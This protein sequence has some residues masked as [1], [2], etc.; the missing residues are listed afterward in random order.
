MLSD[1]PATFMISMFDL[2]VCDNCRDMSKDGDHELMAKTEART[3]FLLKEH[4]FDEGE[5]GPALRYISRRNPHNPGGGQM[6]LYLR[7]Q[8]EER[9]MKVWGSEVGLEA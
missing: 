1:Q 4:D 8:V 9:A 2:V 5:H 6:K 3:T 7:L